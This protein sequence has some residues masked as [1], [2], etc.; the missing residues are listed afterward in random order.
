M[1]KASR[2]RVL[3][4]RAGINQCIG[5]RE[6]R[7]C[8][9]MPIRIISTEANVLNPCAATVPQNLFEKCFYATAVPTGIARFIHYAVGVQQE[10]IAVGFQ[11]TTFADK[12]IFGK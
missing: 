12:F 9:Y 2:I 6:T 10:N 11:T 7:N 5:I 3:W 8:I 4:I 1:L